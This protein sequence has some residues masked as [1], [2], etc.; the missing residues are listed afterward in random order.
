MA[1]CDVKYCFTLVDVGNYGSISDGGVFK[2]CSFGKK[3]IQGSLNIPPPSRLP[4][5][6]IYFPYYLIGDAAFP[7]KPN[8]MKPFAKL[9]NSR[10]VNFNNIICGAR[11]RIE[12]AFGILSSTWR[13]LQTTIGFC[14]ENA[15]KV[16]YLNFV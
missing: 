1:V 2:N 10:M 15:V 16:V 5:S 3:F 11:V 12:M 4:G 6:S 14:P 9:S 13:V 7:L 8:I